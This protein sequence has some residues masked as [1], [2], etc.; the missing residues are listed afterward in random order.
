MNLYELR[1]RLIN[2]THNHEKVGV[3]EAVSDGVATSYL[4][5]PPSRR[6]LDDG[7][8][9]Y[10]GPESGEMDFDSGIFYFD[11][12]PGSGQVLRWDFNHMYWTL[13]MMNDSIN[14][15]IQAV[16]PEF[17]VLKKEELTLDGESKSYVMSDPYFNNVTMMEFSSG[18][19]STRWKCSRMEE[20]G[21][22]LYFFSPPPAGTLNVTYV[23]RPKELFEEDEDMDIP[24]RASG[25]ILAHAAYQLLTQKQVPR[26][27]SDVV[28]NQIGTGTLSPRQM[29][30]AGNAMYLSYQV[31]LEKTR[32]HPWKRK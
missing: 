31:Q 30:D 2:Q 24:N 4:I 16:F 3:S 9:K 26:V 29:A 18:G 17:Y 1:E 5:A 15:A 8:F 14:A 28:V 13:D 25:P 23:A 6:V 21:N 27:Y 19:A 11:N 7:R 20:Y 12:V 10:T 22:E 32:M